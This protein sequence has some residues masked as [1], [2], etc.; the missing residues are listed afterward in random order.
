MKVYQV[1]I[2][3]DYKKENQIQINCTFKHKEDA[4]KYCNE[5]WDKN[6]IK[7]FPYYEDVYERYIDFYEEVEETVVPKIIDPDALKNEV[8]S[9][10]QNLNYQYD[11]DGYVYIEIIKNGKIILHWKLP[12]YKDFYNPKIIV[13]ET[14]VI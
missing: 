10:S 5:L 14:E 9:N 8:K 1:I 3:S 6:Y 12:S 11:N 13:I 7:D 4:L 2:Y